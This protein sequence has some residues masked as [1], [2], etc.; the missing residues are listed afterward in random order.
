MDNLT[1]ES[2]KDLV[3]ANKTWIDEVNR[4]Q[5]GDMETP[6]LPL[7][8]L[9]NLLLANIVLLEYCTGEYE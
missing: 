7:A 9:R 8:D 4:L 2:I 5:Y 3:E 6:M 1:K